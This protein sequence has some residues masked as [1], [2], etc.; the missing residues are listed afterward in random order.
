MPLCQL[1]DSASRFTF[2]SRHV[3]CPCLGSV[4]S[5]QWAIEVI[6][7][8]VFFG[9]VIWTRG[10]RTGSVRG[11]ELDGLLEENARILS[12]RLRGSREGRSG[13]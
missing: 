3:C 4:E 12:R 9:L 2:C 13:P 5:P 7:G 6:H 11:N 10:A 1:K 8:P